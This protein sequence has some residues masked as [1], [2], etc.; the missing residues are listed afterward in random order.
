MEYIAQNICALCKESN[1]CYVF[2][3]HTILSI[4]MM[5]MIIIYPCVIGRVSII[6]STS[7]VIDAVQCNK[8]TTTLVL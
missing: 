6:D 1:R 3:F 2:F 8:V 4:M 7:A 5:I